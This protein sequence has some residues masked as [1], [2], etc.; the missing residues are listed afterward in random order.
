MSA[1]EGKGLASDRAA[2]SAAAAVKA[3]AVAGVPLLAAGGTSAPENPQVRSLYDQSACVLSKQVQIHCSCSEAFYQN[4]T[5][6]MLP[7]VPIP[8]V[9]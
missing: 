4:V 9:N 2:V 5:M 7:P 1:A 6:P 8:G 3:G